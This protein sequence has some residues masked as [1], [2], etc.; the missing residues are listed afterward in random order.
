MYAEFM[1]F[2]DFCHRMY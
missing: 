1:G 2:I